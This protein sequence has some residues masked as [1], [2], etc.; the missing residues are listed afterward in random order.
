MPA[1]PGVYNGGVPIRGL[2]SIPTTPS[3][4]E[5]LTVDEL[6]NMS[7]QAIP[8]G[9][10]AALTGN[11]TDNAALASALNARVAKSGDTMTGNLTINNDSSVLRLNNAGQ[12]WQVRAQY[13]DLNIEPVSTANSVFLRAG[14]GQQVVLNVAGVNRIAATATGATVDGILNV[15]TYVA[16]PEIRRQNGY[17]SGLRLNSNNGVQVFKNGNDFCNIGDWGVILDS[18]KGYSWTSGTNPNLTPDT[19]ILRN[20][21]GPSAE[22][23]AA[24][25]LRV[26][27]AD[28]SH[29]GSKINV[30]QWDSPDVTTTYV[31]HDYNGMTFYGCT[32]PVS[33]LTCSNQGWRFQSDVSTK[34]RNQANTAGGAIECG[35]IT[36]TAGTAIDVRTAVNGQVGT[37]TTDNAFMTI[38]AAASAYPL[39]LYGNLTG[40]RIGDGTYTVDAKPVGS[41]SV[42]GFYT[43]Q[44]NTPAS[45]ALAG[46]LCGEITASALAFNDI[47]GSHIRWVNGTRIYCGTNGQLTF[48]RADL[49]DFNRINLGGTT[50]SFPALKR[51]GATLQ[52]RL[53]DDSNFARFSCGNINIT[54][55]TL[56]PQ[57]TF[58]EAGKGY[59]ADDSGSLWMGYGY[60]HRFGVNATAANC[61]VPL[62]ITSNLTVTPSASVT[63][64]SNGQLTFE[65]TSNTSLTVKYKGSDGVVRS[66]VW[67]LT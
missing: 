16:T 45:G 19:Q 18:G 62:T 46:V 44:G 42:I 50:S 29:T 43:G 63:P 23:R 25:G 28:G 13:G 65:A 61:Y 49:T 30:Q 39:R 11:P 34:F 37:I 9:S 53:A 52:A 56:S 58:A 36:A 47:S 2:T 10:F 40:I 24:G 17:N 22:I 14:S 64:A 55:A 38:R 26:R 60:A 1:T 51:S 6:G 59:I 31:R 32:S 7:R 5:M 48:Y 33:V 15:N 21:T 12:D 66:N 41:N 54:D 3:T 4:I 8:V 35:A 57:V 67:T 20:A 27:V